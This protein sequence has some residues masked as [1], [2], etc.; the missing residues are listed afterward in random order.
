MFRAATAGV[1]TEPYVAE[2]LGQVGEGE[3]EGDQPPQQQE[4]D[5]A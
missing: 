4:E 5:D 3:G 1:D 2:I